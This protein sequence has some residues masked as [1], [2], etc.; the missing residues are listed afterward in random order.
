MSLSSQHIE[1]LEQ[2][3]NEVS[4][5]EGCVLYDLEMV[6]GPGHRILRVYIDKGEDLCVEGKPSGATVDDCMNVS[7]SLS[8]LL[9]VEDMV[10]GGAYELEVS[11]PG[12]ER[13]LKLTWHFEKAIG[14]TVQISAN[15]DLTAPEGYVAKK[16]VKSLSG[17]LVLAN[18]EVINVKSGDFIWSVPRNYIHKAKTKF[19]FEHPGAKK[20]PK[21]KKRK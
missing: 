19:S 2:I 6:G 3:V 17:E 9:D 12:L 14:Q 13:V 11:T 10:A 15:C 16:P 18:D 21:Q 8:L 7:K 4:Q 1:K 5:R 20:A